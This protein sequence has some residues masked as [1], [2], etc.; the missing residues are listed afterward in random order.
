MATDPAD[1][2]FL[3]RVQ[4]LPAA[5]LSPDDRLGLFELWEGECA[6]V[7]DHGPRWWAGEESLERTRR[8]SGAEVDLGSVPTPLAIMTLILGQ[9]IE[10][11]DLDSTPVASYVDAIEGGDEEA[12]RR[13]REPAE[14]TW[15]RWLARTW[16]EFELA[17]SGPSA[18]PPADVEGE[19]AAVGAWTL[20]DDDSYLSARRIAQL[21]GAGRLGNPGEECYEKFVAKLRKRLERWRVKHTM[22]DDWRDAPDGAKEKFVYRVGPWRNMIAELQRELTSRP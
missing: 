20:I 2:D 6:W 11:A 10:S 4:S 15:N 22:S 21:A 5:N 13:C 7:R 3:N 12:I 9:A 19:P 1:V 17:E 18:E 16:N 8:V 14:Q